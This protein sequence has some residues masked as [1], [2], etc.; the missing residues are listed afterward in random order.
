MRYTVHGLQQDKLIKEGLDLYDALL[1][2]TL[3][4]MYSTSGFDFIIKD[5]TKYIWI[6]QTYLTQY[7]PILG[8]K[9]ALQR[10]LKKLEDKGI[11]NRVV[12][13]SKSGIKGTYSYLAFTEKHR[14]LTEFGGYV[15]R[16]VGGT[17]D[18]SQGLR[19][20]RRNKDTSNRDTS[21][22]D[23]T[24]SGD[25]ENIKKQKE[26]TEIARLYQQ[27]IGRTGSF[28]ASWIDENLEDYGYEWLKNALIIAEKN[29]KRTKAYVEGI[30]NRW[31]TEGGMRLEKKDNQNNVNKWKV[32]AT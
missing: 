20:Q 18:L 9:R 22:R 32:D 6:N 23:T 28:T 7:I 17:S 11:I 14:S 13:H 4:K 1:I 24:T 8:K 12:K 31:H 19:Q 29:G 5:D 16:D 27:T 10:R 21:N 30:L 15:S 25:G 3:M 2:D 26:F